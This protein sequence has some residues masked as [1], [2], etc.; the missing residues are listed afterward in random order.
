MYSHL[1]H[2]NPS[3][4]RGVQLGNWYTWVVLPLFAFTALFWVARLNK[5]PR[6]EGE[7]QAAGRG[8][9]R[10]VATKTRVRKKHSFEGACW[11][12]CLGYKSRRSYVGLRQL[13]LNRLRL[14]G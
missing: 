9:K 10:G 1:P 7:E 13:S 6:G 11:R 8:R 2:D 14:L 4:P 5:V 12:T 3:P